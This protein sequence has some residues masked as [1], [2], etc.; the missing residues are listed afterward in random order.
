[1]LQPGVANVYCAVTQH[2]RNGATFYLANFPAMTGR[3]YRY[4]ALPVHLYQPGLPTQP[5]DE[6]S[7]AVAAVAFGAQDLVFFC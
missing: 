7:Q 4:A 5:H 3:E 6:H 2:S 1:M